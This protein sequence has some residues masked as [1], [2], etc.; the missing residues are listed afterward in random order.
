[1]LDIKNKIWHALP[2]GEVLKNLDVQDE[3]LTSEDAAR[4][5]SQY[6]ENQLQEAPRPTF[7]KMLWEQ[8]NN[9]VVIML[10]VASI[11]SA[12]LGDYVEAA[13]IMAIVSPG[14]RRPLAMTSS[15]L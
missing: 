7:W 8:L 5:L 3:G 10:I 15:G 13:A 4:R 11:I 6:G 12:V 9:F 2:T 1:M 14:L